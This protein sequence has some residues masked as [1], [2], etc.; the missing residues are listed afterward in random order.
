[1]VHC[2]LL[3]NCLDTR[4]ELPDAYSSEYVEAAWYDWWVKEGFFKP[5]YN[6][7]V[8]IYQFIN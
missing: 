3:Y 2:E 7:K 5:E 1:M 6:I 4:R 8:I